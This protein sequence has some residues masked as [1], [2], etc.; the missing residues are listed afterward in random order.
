MTTNNDCKCNHEFVLVLSGVNTLDDRVAN[1]LLGAGCDDATISLRFGTV[2]LSFDR[3]ASSLQVAILSA[4]RDVTNAGIGAAVKFVDACNL[5]TQADI[6]RRID[7]SRQMVGQYINGQRGP[8]NFPGPVC[9][10]TKGHPLWMW[11]E[12]S[13]W[14]FQNGIV[15]EEVL[16]ESRV[17][18]GI[19][20]V[21]DL[22]HQRQHDSELVD[23][24]LKMFGEP[25]LS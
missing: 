19:N 22:L 24:V 2:Y 25:A 16:Q 4:I 15:D 14:F 9:S 3:E 17:V 8:G 6:A 7:R 12:V 18:A 10:I 13:Y 11:C 1:A 23:E 20:S 21:L 5:V